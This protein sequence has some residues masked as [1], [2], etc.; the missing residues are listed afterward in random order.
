MH[1]KYSNI[2]SKV[3]GIKNKWH[4]SNHK[5]AYT[6]TLGWKFTRIGSL[7]QLD[8]L[9]S[10]LQLLHKPLKFIETDPIQPF[11]NLARTNL[12]GCLTCHNGMFKEMS[13]D[14]FSSVL[15]PIWAMVAIGAQKPVPLH[16][17]VSF[18]FGGF[19]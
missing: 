1:S 10:C 3:K 17:G 5:P 15:Y 2:P 7:D 9:V 8:Q 16:F 19:V 4:G 13:E 14:V 6:F 11:K 12:I 18:V